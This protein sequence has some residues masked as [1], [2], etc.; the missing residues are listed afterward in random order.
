MIKMRSTIHQKII[1]I[2]SFII[3]V[4]TLGCL[5]EKPKNESLKDAFEGKFLIGVAINTDQDEGKDTLALPII[6]QHFNSVVAENCMKSENIEPQQGVFTFEDADRFVAFGEAH[7]MFIIGHCLVWH[8]QAPGW[9]FTDKKGNDVSRDT[10]IARMKTHIQTL[11]GRYKGRVKGWDVV[12]EAIE[13]DG[14]YRNSKFYQIIGEEYIE[15]AFRFAKEANPD[16]ELY[17]N[18][19][20]M[21]I[22]GRR[23]GV[24][25][26]IRNLQQKGVKVD[27][28]GMQAHCTL[29]FPT[30]EDEE[31]SIVAFSKLG[32]KVMITELDV[33]VLP[34]P[35]EN[36]SADVGLK[37]EYKWEMNPYSSGLPDSVSQALT[38]R[39]L[40][41]FNL[42]LKHH[43]CISR[44]TIW[45][46]NDG[47][48]W[49][50]FWP[51]MGRVDYPLLFDREY[52]P[53]PIVA[54][55]IETAQTFK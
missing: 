1:A 51:I 4:L 35:F 33:T 20:S 17:Y 15:L 32:V 40:E 47:Q 36:V 26:M 27:A 18:D 25:K 30:L 3:L 45:G 5:E 43:D 54:K 46:V 12:N 34:N 49:R 21:S 42:F 8:S 48:S 23:E 14:S 24:V 13:D 6:K 10:L 7:K 29:D 52:R 39:F 9:F 44:V 38:N 41:L 31:A 11:V 50:N 37:T 22:P 28:I 2:I 55:L 16:A 19:Y 53:K